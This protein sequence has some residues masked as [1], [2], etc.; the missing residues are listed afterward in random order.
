MPVTRQE[1]L[2]LVELQEHDKVL[3]ELRRALERVPR[4]IAALKGEVE[5]E[6]GKL[7]AVRQ[8]SRELELKKKDRELALAEKEQAIQ[9][10]QR[11]LNAV[12]TNDAFKALLKQIEEAKA[13]VSDLETE[14]LELMESADGLKKEE[15]AAREELARFE[16]A[17]GKQVAVLEARRAELEQRL[18]AG[19]A[20]RQELRAPVPEE[21]MGLY[22]K[23]RERR[24]GVAMA[25]THGETCRVC[26]MKITPQSMIDLAKSAKVVMCDSCQRILYK[27]DLAPA[28]SA[29]SA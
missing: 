12:K 26:H 27:P 25:P 11:E 13:A 7:E 20:R 2:R 8:R 17:N 22:D 1:I 21:L 28:P 6:K 5:G 15:K 29:Q 10:H 23:T 4:D 24:E 14:I 19:E 18:A 9:K 16:A 3:D